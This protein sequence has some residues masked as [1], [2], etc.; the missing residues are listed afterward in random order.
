MYRGLGFS[1]I[2]GKLTQ[3]GWNRTPV[4]THE[5]NSDLTSIVET[6]V[7]NPHTETKCSF[8]QKEIHDSTVI[9]QQFE[10]I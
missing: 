8:H 2:Q 3:K 4:A 7:P 10:I 1:L 9:P 5:E 6:D